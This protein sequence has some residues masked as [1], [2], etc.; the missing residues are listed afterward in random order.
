M[1]TRSKKPSKPRATKAAETAAADKFERKNWPEI[2][3]KIAA[4]RASVANGKARKWD[5]DRTLSES[6]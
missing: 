4:A 5:L 2:K 6:E 3:S 1:A